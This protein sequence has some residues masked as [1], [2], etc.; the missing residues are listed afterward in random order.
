MENVRNT[1]RIFDSLLD[2]NVH[3]L[4]ENAIVDVIVIAVNDLRI[5]RKKTIF[6]KAVRRI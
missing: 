2:V 6:S 3:H 5:Q 1:L 4:S